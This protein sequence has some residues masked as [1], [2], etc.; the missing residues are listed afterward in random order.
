MRGDTLD[1]SKIFYNNND[2]GAIHVKFAIWDTIDKINYW[3]TIQ[4]N[5]NNLKAQ[6][7][8]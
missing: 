6:V 5:I 7:M 1:K 4:P 3:I 2:L 8:R